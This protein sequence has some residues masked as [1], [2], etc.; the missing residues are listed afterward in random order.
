MKYSNS[1]TQVKFMNNDMILEE[2]RMGF[3][4]NKYDIYKDKFNYPQN[5]PSDY[6]IEGGVNVFDMA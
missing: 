2:S 6:E 1:N 5:I 3:G 4:N